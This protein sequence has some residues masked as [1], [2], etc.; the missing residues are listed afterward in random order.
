M[1]QAAEQLQ[2][3]VDALKQIT[4]R[5]L[6]VQEQAI[7][8]TDVTL[9]MLTAVKQKLAGPSVPLHYSIVLYSNV[10]CCVSVDKISLEATLSNL[11]RSSQDSQGR[12][13]ATG[14]E[15]AALQQQLAELRLR[16]EE[17]Q[18]DHGHIEVNWKW[19]IVDS[20]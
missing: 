5:A 9:S 3:S 15:L 4:K 10:F 6:S 11:Q 1:G 8:R 19:T 17:A 13:E 7:D 12:L 16:L 18:R 2:G 14:R 20:E